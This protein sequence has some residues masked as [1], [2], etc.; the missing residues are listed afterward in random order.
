MRFARDIQSGPLLDV[1]HFRKA[2]ANS[3]DF[4][5][6]Q[7]VGEGNGGKGLQDPTLLIVEDSDFLNELIKGLLA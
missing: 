1:E 2:R 5:R 7:A 3:H 6:N 4:H